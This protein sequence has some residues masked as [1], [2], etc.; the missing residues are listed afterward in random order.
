[1]FKALHAISICFMSIY[2]HSHVMISGIIVHSHSNS[3]IIGFLVKLDQFYFWTKKLLLFST[4]DKT[5]GLI[6][7]NWFNIVFFFT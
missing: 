1:M 2:F 5:I 4:Y 7:V 6:L 3:I